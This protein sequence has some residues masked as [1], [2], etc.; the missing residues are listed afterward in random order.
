MAAFDEHNEEGEE[1]EEGEE[2]EDEIIVVER[3]L[4]TSPLS[5]RELQQKT[6]VFSQ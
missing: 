1:G 6:R 4:S 5:R 3:V 2:S